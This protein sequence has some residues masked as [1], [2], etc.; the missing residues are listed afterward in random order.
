[1]HVVSTVPDWQLWFYY[2]LKQ[3]TGALRALRTLKAAI[4][5]SRRDGDS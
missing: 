2:P 5:D 1:M 4:A 3:L